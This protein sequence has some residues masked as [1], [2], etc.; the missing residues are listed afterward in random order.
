[1][2]NGVETARPPESPLGGWSLF[3]TEIFK[4]RLLGRVPFGQ[5]LDLPS[6]IASS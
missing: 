5:E 6:E 4:K 2:A 3:R 1:M